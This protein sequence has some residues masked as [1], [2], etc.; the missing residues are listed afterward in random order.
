MD[1]LHNN[2]IKRLLGSVSIIAGMYVLIHG[3][4]TPTTTTQNLEK[5]IA[6]NS[7]F[8]DYSCN[9]TYKATQPPNSNKLI[10]LF[11]NCAGFL[12]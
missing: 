8:T 12:D 1:I 6:S 10:H 7:S 3:I 11:V 2:H 9:T 5:K 4:S